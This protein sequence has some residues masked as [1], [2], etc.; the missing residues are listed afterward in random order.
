[1]S[2]TGI[3]RRIDE[4]GRIVVPKELRTTLR[5]HEGSMLEFSIYGEGLMLKKFNPLSNL[6]EISDML[7]ETLSKHLD[8]KVVIICDKEVFS[9]SSRDDIDISAVDQS[10][11]KQYEVKVKEGAKTLVITPILAGGDVLGSLIIE[12]GAAQE[13]R[14]LANF[15][16]GLI[17]NYYQN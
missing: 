10:K 13:A 14:G 7:V 3:V 8:K 17:A 16:A 6:S 1:M 5:L 12:D 15:A 11:R 4:L 2:E 9:S